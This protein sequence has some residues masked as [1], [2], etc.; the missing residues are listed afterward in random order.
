MRT[1]PAPD[2]YLK[3]LDRLGLLAE[4]CLV[5][6]D[7]PNGIRAAHEA[8]IRVVGVPNPITIHAGPLQAD[9]VLSSL[10]EISLD[11]LLARFD[12]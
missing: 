3:A 2:L 9:V 4:D 6:E 8:G 11:V 12:D 10:A 1:K 7:S 5:F